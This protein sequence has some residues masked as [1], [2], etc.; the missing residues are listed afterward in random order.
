MFTGEYNGLPQRRPERAER[1]RS[2]LG[3]DPAAGFGLEEMQVA[4][5]PDD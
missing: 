3:D 1:E 2:G 4:R 5:S